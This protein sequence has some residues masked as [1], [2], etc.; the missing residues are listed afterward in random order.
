M[1]RIVLVHGA[2]SGAAY[3]WRVLPLL[4]DAV[5]VDLP[6]DAATWEECVEVVHEAADDGAVLVGQS[7]GAFVVAL[8]AASFPTSGVV[9][10][11]PMVPAPG[12]TAGAWWENTGHA[13]AAAAGARA[14]GLDPAVVVPGPE[15]DVDVTFLHDV[16]PE[17][18]PEQ[19]DPSWPPGALFD[20]PYPLEAWPDVPTRV[21]AARDD[22]LFPLPFVQRLARERLGVEAEVLPGGHVVALAQPAAV[23]TALRA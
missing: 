13:E 4:P 22:R 6:P 7:M 18:L 1:T 2:G 15:F 19:L 9:L 14:Q 5:A 21:L 12:E 16:P 3:W 8:A 20:A 17:V 10:L 11:A 23:A